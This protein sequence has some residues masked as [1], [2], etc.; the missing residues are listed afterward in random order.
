M[1]NV[2]NNRP[3]LKTELRMRNATIRSFRKQRK[4]FEKHLAE[5]YRNEWKILRAYN[6]L[7][8]LV[9]EVE[10]DAEKNKELPIDETSEPLSWF[11]IEMWLADMIENIK[12]YPKIASNKWYKRTF[13]NNATKLTNEWIIFEEWLWLRYEELFWETHFSNYKWS[14]TRTTKL[15]LLKTLKEWIEE[16]LTV[17]ELTKEIEKVS[18]VLFSKNRAELIAINELWKAY[19]YW[20]WVPMQQ[21][22]NLWWQVDKKWLT[23]ND[24]K[25]RPEHLTNW[26]EWWKPFGYTYPATWTNFAPSWFRCRCTMGRRIL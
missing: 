23:V 21:Y 24:S 10:P 16:N 12:K 14:N 26:A 6:Y 4:Y 8:N 1:A 7:I 5:L 11:W 25:V 15:N 13:R 19:E 3:I 9:W 22:E 17:W 18:N 2:T 20:S